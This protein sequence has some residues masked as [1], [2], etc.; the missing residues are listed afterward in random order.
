MEKNLVLTKQNVVGETKDGK[1]VSQIKVLCGALL[2]LLILPIS[3]M[4]SQE[5]YVIDFN[6]SHIRGHRG[7]KATIYLKKSLK[8]QYPWVRISDLELEK[9][10]LVAKSKM[11]RGGAGLRVG[12]WTTDMYGVDGSPRHFH[13]KGRYT[14]DRVKFWNP[15]KN[16]NGPWQLEI[17]GNL[18][19][20]K[21]VLM[22]RD[23]GRR[24]YYGR[25]DSPGR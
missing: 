12:R 23:H 17:K 3:V 5:R 11:G 19:V 14:F 13:E 22:V 1:I 24:E 9:V 8:A 25:W 15:S 10:V 2:I 7:E 16:S 20:R 6:D 18:I 21:V 4:A